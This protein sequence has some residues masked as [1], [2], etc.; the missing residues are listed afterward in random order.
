MTKRERH[1]KVLMRR[2]GPMR[3]MLLVGFIDTLPDR[4]HDAEGYFVPDHSRIQ[5]VMKVKQP[6]YWTL[7]RGL[8]ERGL[9]TKRVTEQWGR[10]Y[11]IEFAAIEAYC[12]LAWVEVL[13]IS[14]RA[15]LG[16]KARKTA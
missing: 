10:Q 12:R 14:F 13:A 16:L 9:V 4:P 5:K 6:V 11:R 2:I 7:L 1:I 8:M 15:L 3:T